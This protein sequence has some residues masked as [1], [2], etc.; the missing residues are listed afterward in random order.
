MD[1][2][3]HELE[4]LEEQELVYVLSRVRVDNDAAAW[5]E[6]GFSRS[7]W[8]RVPQDRRDHLNSLALA[9]KRAAWL[10]AYLK[11]QEAA[12]EAAETI[13]KLATGSEAPSVALRAAQDI[14]DRVGGKATQQ[15]EVSGR[16]GGPIETQ[17]VVVY[18][19]DNERQSE[20]A[21]DGTDDA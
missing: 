7:A 11:L 9:L 18:M 1:D 10:R 2:L 8:Y 19:P 12:E 14:L 20:D 6:A 15:V 13:V 5:R 3:R 4:Q 17:Q 21:D 16:G